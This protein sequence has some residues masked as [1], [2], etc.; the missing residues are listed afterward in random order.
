MLFDP[1]KLKEQLLQRQAE[2][3]RKQSLVRRESRRAGG[4]DRESMCD[5]LPSIPP[6]KFRARVTS[7]FSIPNHPLSPVTSPMHRP[8]T[9]TD[10]TAAA[11]TTTT[12]TAAANINNFATISVNQPTMSSPPLSTQMVY[13]KETAKSSPFFME[14]VDET[15]KSSPF[16]NQKEIETP[17]S[18]PFSSPKKSP[19]KRPTTAGGQFIRTL[20]VFNEMDAAKTRELDVQEEELELTEL[21]GSTENIQNTVSIR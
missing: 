13:A 3:A 14:K 4:E 15:P 9:T 7:S 2:E 17:K 16:S 6:T 5:D 18:S 1:K 21:E 19:V 10:S 11:A 20:T 12:T 8:V